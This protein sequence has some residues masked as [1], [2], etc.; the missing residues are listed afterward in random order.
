MARQL[1]TAILLAIWLARVEPAFAAPINLQMSATATLVAGGASSTVFIQV[2]ETGAPSLMTGWQ[3]ALEITPDAGSTGEVQFAS[4][5][6][7][8]DYI[9]PVSMGYSTFLSGIALSGFDLD[10]TFTG[11]AVTIDNLIEIAFEASPDAAGDFG[12]YAVGGFGANEWTDG[13]FTAHEFGDLGGGG[14][15]RIGTVTVIANSEV[16]PEPSAMQLL[17]GLLC[18]FWRLGS[19]MR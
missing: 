17:A 13:S 3:V 18:V 16:V 5:A 15:T 2:V 1:T 9:F 4:A 7:P 6:Q 10:G 8:A 14:P 12:V 11:A 19:K